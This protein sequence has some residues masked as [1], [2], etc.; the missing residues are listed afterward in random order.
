MVGNEKM[1]KISMTVGSL[2]F[3]ERWFVCCFVFYGVLDVS[4]DGRLIGGFDGS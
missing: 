4:G 2:R 1:K 3:S